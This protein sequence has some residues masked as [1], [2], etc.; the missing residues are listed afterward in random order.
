VLASG[1]LSRAFT[2]SE[3]LNLRCRLLL[4]LGQP[5]LSRFCCDSLMRPCAALSDLSLPL[6]RRWPEL[7]ARF[8]LPS[9]L[10]PALR[11]R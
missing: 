8:V 5:H 3:G 7:G 10:R 2:P 11:L 9:D 1:Y 4:P 6:L